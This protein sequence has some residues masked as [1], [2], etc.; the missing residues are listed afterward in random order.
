MYRGEF[1]DRCKLRRGVEMPRQARQLS[2]TGFYHVVCR[3]AE[4]QNLF[5]DDEDYQSMLLTLYRLKVDMSF[6]LHAYSLVSN[7]MH[8]LIREKTRGDISAIMKRM[9]TRYAIY[10]NRKYQRSGAIMTNRY[11]STPINI[12]EHFL[13][14][15]RHIHQCPIE[16]RLVEKMEDYPYSSYRE[17]IW[18]GDLA[19]TAFSIVLAGQR[20]WTR[21]HAEPSEAVD[22]ADIFDASGRAML[23]DAEIQRKII[24]CSGGHEPSEIRDWPKDERNAMLK[25]LREQE[26][27]SIRQIERITGISRGIIAKC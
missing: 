6:E 8:L 12:D 17:Y 26:Q 18:G 1:L 4:R 23:N 2:I 9:M 20:E 3:G 15:V 22:G 19:E 11:K 21:L 16:A 13:P 25:L 27:L 24:H 14:L 10:F 5:N 7:R